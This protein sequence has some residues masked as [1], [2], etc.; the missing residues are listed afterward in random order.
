MFE[1]GKRVRK[2]PVEVQRERNRRRRRKQKE[3]NARAKSKVFKLEERLSVV[4]GLLRDRDREAEGSVLHN[5][6]TH[7]QTHVYKPVFVHARTYQALQQ[8]TGNVL[9]AERAHERLAQSQTEAEG[10]VTYAHTHAHTHTHTHI[11][12][13]H[14]QCHSLKHIHRCSAQGEVGTS[15]TNRR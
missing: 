6:R 3:V 15:Q 11:W 9:R 1:N 2:H 14:T 7:T 10:S 12:Y 8:H 4:H 13:T 5:T